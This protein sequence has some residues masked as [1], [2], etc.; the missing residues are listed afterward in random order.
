MET[1]HWVVFEAEKKIAMFFGVL[2]EVLFEGV[3][4]Y[5]E[6]GNFTKF[7]TMRILCGIYIA[8]LTQTICEVSVFCEIGE[9]K[10]SNRGYDLRLLFF[11]RP[12]GES[13]SV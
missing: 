3:F 13:R 10:N 8:R 11:Q 1:S 7:K 4:G 5:L 6:W 9:E 2:K 12:T